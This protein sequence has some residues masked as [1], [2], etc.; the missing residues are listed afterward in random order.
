M[1]PE[2]FVR[3]CNGRLSVSRG[4]TTGGQRGDPGRPDDKKTRVSEILL[5]LRSL[6]PAFTLYPP[7]N[8]KGPSPGLH[9]FFSVRPGETGGATSP[10]YVP[11]IY[12]PGNSSRPNCY[13][14]PRDFTSHSPG[15]VTP[16]LG[17]CKSR[18]M[19]TWA[20]F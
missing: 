14:S 18:G 12:P 15:Y 20:V 11:A 6:R 3:V 5:R 2:V 16:D 9:R 7:G 1:V 13:L 19:R 17:R 8:C 4:G 10:I